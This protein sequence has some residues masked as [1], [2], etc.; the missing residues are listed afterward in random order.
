MTDDLGKSPRRVAAWHVCL[1]AIP[2]VIGAYFALVRAGVWPAGQVALYVSANLAF[3][4]A[5]LVTARRLPAMRTILIFLAGSAAAGATGDVLF[6]V[7]ALIYG[8]PP[9]PGVPDLFYLLAYPMMAV[10]LVMIVRRRTPGWDSASVIDAA[11]VAIGVGYLVFLFLVVPLV[12]FEDKITSLVSVAYP[13]GDV[14]LIVV[15]ARLMLGAG[16]RTTALRFI[17]AYLGLVLVADAIYGFQTQLGTYVPGNFLDALWMA[18]GFCMAA[19]VLHPSAPKLVAVSN[20]ATPDATPGRLAVLAFAAVTAPTSMVIQHFR[21][22]EEHLVAAAA[23]C[24]LLFLLVM[25]RMALLVQ[26]QRHA[27]VTDG[28]T[29]LRSRRFFEQAL[30][31]QGDR[32]ARLGVPV[33][34]LLLDIDHFKSVND[35]YGHNG[36]DRVL[37]EVTHRLRELVRPGDVVARYGGEEFA[38]LLPDT[39]TAEA[40]EVAERIRRGISAAPIAVGDSR[41]HNVTISCGIA[42]MPAAGTT[43]ELVLAADRA[44]YAAKHAGRNRI[45]C[46]GDQLTDDPAAAEPVA[47]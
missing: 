31:N 35:T 38:V 28:L 3:A 33:S 40:G 1:A 44:L 15:G 13:I 8:E 21:G 41:L 26:A 16:P 25:V 7:D 12:D 9:Y 18:A 34:V 43:E 45:A 37:V 46:A 4:V 47:A 10:G 5:A 14:M 42:G 19:G 32:S 22:E 39:T 30:G 27:A 29:G 23:V 36:G 6:Y 24:N 17:G 11:I 2:L 20:T